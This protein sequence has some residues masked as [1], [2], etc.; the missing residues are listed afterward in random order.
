MHKRVLKGD[1]IASSQL[2]VK[3]GDKI[4]DQ[5]KRI[6]PKV[7]HIDEEAIYDGV[8]DAF[9][10]Y[11][12][13]P[14]KYDPERMT[15]FN[16]LLMSAKGDMKNI[17]EKKASEK[18]KSGKIVELKEE[19]RNSR[20]DEAVSPVD[21]LINTENQLTWERQLKA[22]FP[23]ETEFKVA[24]LVANGVR[25]NAPYAKVLGINH[26]GKHEQIV[27][28]KKAKDR[29]KIKIKRAKEKGHFNNE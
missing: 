8:T 13:S 16:Y 22:L 25:E 24:S 6:F 18:K 20:I 2:F 11:I 3:Y 29:V 15:L 17:I 23:D 1:N 10:S 26:L 27:E 4:I 14:E 28:V 21:K 5:L 9:V 7:V 19:V 12:K